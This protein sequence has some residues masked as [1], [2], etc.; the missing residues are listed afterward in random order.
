MLMRM[1][2]VIITLAKLEINVPFDMTVPFWEFIGL[3]VLTGVCKGHICLLALVVLAKDREQLM[4]AF[5]CIGG[6]LMKK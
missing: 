5:L 6:A 2:D 4:C 3:K 1:Y